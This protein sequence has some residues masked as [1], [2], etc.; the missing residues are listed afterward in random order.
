MHSITDSTIGGKPIPAHIGN[1]L[2][3]LFS[4]L[5]AVNR[6]LAEAG[7]NWNDIPRALA[8]ERQIALPFDPPAAPALAPST[9][10]TIRAAYEARPAPDDFRWLTPREL[11]DLIAEIE[12]R[13]QVAKG[14]RS[15][16]FLA[17][18]RGLCEQYDP[19]RLSAKQAA[20]LDRLAADAGLVNAE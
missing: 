12:R 6:S 11:L 10:T 15:S 20:W 8:V 7:L 4:A 14:V 2:R 5:N 13:S 16:A 9:S 1:D 3:A 18:L 19:V 17:G